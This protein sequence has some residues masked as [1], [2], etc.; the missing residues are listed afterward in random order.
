[1]LP[2]ANKWPYPTFHTRMGEMLNY[3]WI[4]CFYYDNGEKIYFWTNSRIQK[5]F[6]DENTLLMVVVLGA[7]ILFGAVGVTVIAGVLL[8]LQ[9]ICGIL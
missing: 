3:Y 7:G 2:D 1:M 8:S 5:M 6:D 9:D 4:K